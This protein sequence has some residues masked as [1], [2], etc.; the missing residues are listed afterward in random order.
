[1]TDEEAQKL[2]EAM[3]MALERIKKLEASNEALW[4]WVKQLAVQDALALTFAA[5]LFDRT[6]RGEAD[7]EEILNT[8]FD[9]RDTLLGE[10]VPK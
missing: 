3:G 4:T 9:N 2:V 8:I 6:D 10:D 5:R 7:R 1:M